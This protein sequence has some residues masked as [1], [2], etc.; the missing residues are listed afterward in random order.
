MIVKGIFNIKGRGPIV[1]VDDAPN[2]VMPG[3]V[4]HCGERAWKI[5]GIDSGRGIDSTQRRVFGLALK[6]VTHD[7]SMPNEGD[8][9]E[10]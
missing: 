3:C 4:V 5:T 10:L 2:S 1:A 8:V 7:E 9:L 6:S